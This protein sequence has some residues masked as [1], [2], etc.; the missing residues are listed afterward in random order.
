MRKKR[1]I[2]ILSIGGADNYRILTEFIHRKG[3]YFGSLFSR[4]IIQNRMFFH[5]FSFFFKDTVHVFSV[6]HAGDNEKHAG[7]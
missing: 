4:A 3:F 5:I 7:D 2:Q 6:K 1:K